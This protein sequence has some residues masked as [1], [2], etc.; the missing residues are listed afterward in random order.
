MQHSK[1]EIFLTS[2]KNVLFHLLSYT[3]LCFPF[4]FWSPL[5]LAIFGFLQRSQKKKKLRGLIPRAKYRPSNRRLSAKLVPTSADRVVSHGQRDGSLRLYYWFSRPESL[6]FF[7]VAPQLYSQGWVDP[8]PDPL[9]LRKFSSVGN[10]PG[11]LNLYPRPLTTQMKL[12]LKLI[13]DRQS[14]GQSVLV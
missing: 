1:V 14:V 4:R 12:K 13:C 10:Q 6:L 5:L 3:F 11:P 8:V 9:H 2:P 7:Q